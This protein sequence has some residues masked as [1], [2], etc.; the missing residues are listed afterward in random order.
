MSMTSIIIPVYNAASHLEKMLRYTL[1]LNGN[2]E[3]IVVD[4]GSTDQSISIIQSFPQV[5]LYRAPKGRSHQMNKGAN[6]AKG[7]VLLFLHADTYL[8]ENGINEI[9]EIM[10]DTNCIGGS[11]YLKFDH[12]HR[13]LKLYSTCS[14]INHSLFTYGDQGIFCRASVFH[15][16]GGFMEIPIMEDVE[17][18]FRLRKTGNFIKLPQAVTTSAHRFIENGIVRQMLVD[19]G[20]VF[21]YRLGASP[22]WLKKYYPDD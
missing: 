7:D 12:D 22:Y 4:G 8:P 14:K 2:F 15:K 20:L 19:I 10:N 17:I 6:H 1:S 9:S 11:F 5:K 21:L 18:Q 3:V 16:I 13:M